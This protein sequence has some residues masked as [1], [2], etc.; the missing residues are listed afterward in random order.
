MTSKLL[1]ISHN[2]SIRLM[3]LILYRKLGYGQYWG[4][5]YQY[6]RRP[7]TLLIALNLE[8]ILTQKKNLNVFL[9]ELKTIFLRPTFESRWQRLTAHFS[10]SF[11]Q[12]VVMATGKTFWFPRRRRRRRRSGEEKQRGNGLS[13]R[14]AVCLL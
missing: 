11:V 12:S 5:G 3:R 10:F 9:T 4:N 7:Q 6:K 14:R 1:Q 2:V 8:V 13:F